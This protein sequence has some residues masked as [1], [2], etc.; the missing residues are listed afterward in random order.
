MSNIGGL[1]V[2]GSPW[3]WVNGEF[4]FRVVAHELG[5]TFGLQHANFWKTKD[6]DPVSSSG[7]SIMYGDPFDVMGDNYRYGGRAD[8][9]PWYKYQLGWI[10]DDQ[11]QT[12]NQNGTYRV[13]RFDDGEATGTLALRVARDAQHAVGDYW[14][15]YRRNF[16]EIDRL[17]NGAYVIWG[18]PSVGVESDLLGLGPQ[19]NNARDS[20][21]SV[22]S[23]LADH[24]ANLTIAPVAEG[25]VPP[26]EYLDV[27][28]T[29]GPPP[30]I[31]RQPNSQMALVGESA[32]F[33]IKAPVDSGFEWQRQASGTHDWVTLSDGDGYFGT[34][35]PTLQITA[36]YDDER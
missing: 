12:V 34:S 28:I 14:I 3:V 31:L 17:A 26:N 10:Q 33:T 23:I 6:G 16:P 8:F 9:N 7:E 20:G 30:I 32:Q 22:G 4:D 15:G 27:Q 25:G 11:V 5:H 19:V 24:A 29:F 36:S 18:W 35:T 1:S 13:Y 2:I 21:L